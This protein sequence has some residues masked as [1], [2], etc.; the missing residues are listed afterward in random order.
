ML[1]KLTF[2]LF[3]ISIQ[4]TF[5][6]EAAKVKHAKE[7]YGIGA[8]AF[9][10][11]GLG[12][13]YWD[14]TLNGYQFNVTPIIINRDNS[15]EGKDHMVWLTLGISKMNSLFYKDDFKRFKDVNINFYNSWDVKYQYFNSS[16]EWKLPFLNNYYGIRNEGRSKSHG[17][18]LGAGLGVE[19]SWWR[20]TWSG[21]VNW[22]V[23]ASTIDL[24][25]RK[26]DGGDHKGHEFETIPRLE[27]SVLFNFGKLD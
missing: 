6:A 24:S 14:Q 1:K 4:L 2:L 19:L 8:G 13:R 21:S 16:K 11:N 26:N 20:V 9:S 18:A 25:E 7:F 23:L 3:L 10:G 5:A 15:N 12:Y 17:I 27:T 22:G